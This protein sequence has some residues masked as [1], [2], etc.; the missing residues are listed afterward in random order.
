MGLM[1]SCDEC[2]RT[3]VAGGCPKHYVPT[4]PPWTGGLQI[5][6]SPPQ[7]PYRCPVCEGRGNVPAGFYS[8]VG[9]STAANPEN[10]RSCMGAGIIWR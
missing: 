4:T 7:Q 9:A 10:C 3:T 1:L 8:R 2:S 5:N 6:T